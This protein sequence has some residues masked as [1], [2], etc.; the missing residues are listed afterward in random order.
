MSLGRSQCRWVG[1]WVSLGGV[2]V[3]HSHI[4]GE[5]VEEVGNTVSLLCWQSPGVVLTSI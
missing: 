2:G 5:G 1:G 4:A 3:Q